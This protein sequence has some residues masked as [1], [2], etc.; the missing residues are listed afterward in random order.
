MIS[1]SSRHFEYYVIY[2]TTGQCT[3]KLSFN[4]TCASLRMLLQAVLLLRGICSTSHMQF[5]G[6]PSNLTASMK[7]SFSIRTADSTAFSGEDSYEPKGK[8]ARRKDLRQH[9]P[10]HDPKS[11]TVGDLQHLLSSQRNTNITLT[12]LGFRFLKFVYLLVPLDTARQ[13]TSIASTVTG[14]VV[15]WPCTTMATESPTR[16]MSMPASST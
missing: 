10:L 1:K 11:A 4:P 2:W 9:A 7:P 14:S 3:V 5:L 6:I 15:S 8:S 13:C 12:V 16:R